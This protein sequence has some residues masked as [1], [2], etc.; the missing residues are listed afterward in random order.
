MRPSDFLIPFG[1]GYGLPLQSAYPAAG[2]YSAPHVVAGIVCFPR[3]RCA[4]EMDHRLSVYPAIHM[5][6]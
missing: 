5:E 2:A 1:L 6:K 4:S 3:T